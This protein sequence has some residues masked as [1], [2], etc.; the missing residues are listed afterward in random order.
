MGPPLPGV[1]LRITDPQTGSPLPQG[2]IGMIEV[3]GPNVFAGY[4]GMP[5]K[6]AA[7]FRAEGYFIT[8]DLERIDAASGPGRRGEGDRRRVSGRRP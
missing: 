1:D 8:G 7:E 6:A 4:W 5:E 2:K 3:K